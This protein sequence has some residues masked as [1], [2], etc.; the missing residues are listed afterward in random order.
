MITQEL[1]KKHLKY[2]PATGDFTWILPRSNTIKAGDKAGCLMTIGYI[3]IHFFKSYYAH[4]LAH[5]YMTGSWPEKHIDHKNRIR[6]DN[7]W[8]NIRPSNCTQNGAN[9]VKKSGCKSIYKGVMVNP[10]YPDHWRAKI[11]INKKSKH[12]GYFKKE[13]DAALAY[14]AAARE[15][16]GEYARTNF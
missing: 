4:R 10:T 1:L 8:K 3:S 9:K 5:L 11:K 16:F 13:K 12:L 7:K 14:D 2:C 15:A 6:S